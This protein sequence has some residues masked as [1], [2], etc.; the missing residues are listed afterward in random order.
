M[1]FFVGD[2]EVSE[3]GLIFGRTLTVDVAGKPSFASCFCCATVMGDLMSRYCKRQT[4]FETYDMSK[5][6]DWFLAALF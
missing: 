1:V 6:E 4:I 5:H 2:V 3:A